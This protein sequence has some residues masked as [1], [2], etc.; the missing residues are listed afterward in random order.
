MY[1]TIFQFVKHLKMYNLALTHRTTGA[2]DDRL[3]TLM[4]DELFWFIK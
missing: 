4:T 1:L 2:F 3:L